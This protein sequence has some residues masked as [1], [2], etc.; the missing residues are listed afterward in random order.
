M[1]MVGVGTGVW[2]AA[3]VLVAVAVGVTVIVGVAVLVAVCVG[4]LVSNGV[5]VKVTVTV[6]VAVFGMLVRL[7]RTTVGVVSPIAVPQPVIN[8]RHVTIIKNRFTFHLEI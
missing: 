3:G 2:V 6:D 5:A 1:A 7:G 4:V 8:N